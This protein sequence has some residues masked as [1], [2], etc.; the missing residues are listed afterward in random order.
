MAKNELPLVDPQGPDDEMLLGLQRETFDYFMDVAHPDTG[1]VADNTSPDAPSSI[2]AVG[3]ALGAWITGTERGLISRSEAIQRTL[4]VL[5]FFQ[6]SHQG[7]EKDATGY[8][9]FY[10]HFLDMKTGKRAC[11]SE[12][13]TI[14]TALF[15]V[16]AL[17]ASE[18]FSNDH[19]DEKEIR[20]KV[21]FLYRRIDWKWALNGENTLTHGWFPESG[22]IPYRWDNCYSEALILYILAMGSPTFPIGGDGY[23]KWTSTFQLSKSYDLEYVH[24]GPLFIHQMSQIWL[25][26]RGLYDDF[27][28]K[29]G[30]DY[31]E[32]S[33]RATYAQRQYAIENPK[34]FAH[35]DENTWGLT[36]SDG[37]GPA[38]LVIDGLNRTFY[39]YIARGA[40]DDI[41]DGTVSPWAV[42]TSLPFSPHIVLSAIRHAIEKLALKDKR[43]LYGFDA[44]FNPTFPDKS[45]N[46]LGWVSPWRYGLNQGPIILMIENYFSGLI[47][48]LMKSN[49]FVMNGMKHA[50]F[51]E[52]IRGKS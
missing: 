11:E 29:I 51:K 47:W 31:F 15:I 33:K 27:N 30:F 40:P 22:F 37:P 6:S 43:R 8:K 20:S 12:L 35:Y 50:G 3:L 34:K 18:Y 17:A 5:S 25:D 2:A 19:E 45:L 23:R 49:P 24:A 9:G 14:D 39:D 48:K 41:D 1:L 21:D 7:T 4:R 16:G 38:N 13:S 28:Q 52:F 26:L 36:A 32:N 44:S 46:H 10:Y 42:V